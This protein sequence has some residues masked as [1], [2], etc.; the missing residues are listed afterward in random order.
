MS[1]MKSFVVRNRGLGKEI[2]KAERASGYL[3][4]ITRKNGGELR[5]TYFT[6]TFPR[7]DMPGALKE[8]ERLLKKEI[9]L[10]P[11][12]SKETPK[13]EKE[14]ELPPEYRDK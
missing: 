13:V 7:E 12:V 5:H 2:Q 1:K 11:T 10:I 6:Q 4:C 14:K 8:H 3:I 9:A